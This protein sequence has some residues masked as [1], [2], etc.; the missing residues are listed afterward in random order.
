M[1]QMECDME[2]LWWS[3][4][5]HVLTPEILKVVLSFNI[6]SMQS[7]CNEILFLEYMGVSLEIR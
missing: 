6:L 4:A 7:G 2:E 1:L 5:L 3:G